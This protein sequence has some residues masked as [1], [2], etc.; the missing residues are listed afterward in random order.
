[1]KKG[2]IYT[3]INNDYC[4]YVIFKK[5]T[6]EGI[7]YIRLDDDDNLRGERGYIPNTSIQKINFKDSNPNTK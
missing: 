4:M 1:M 6:R 3:N 5:I 7:Y 2:W